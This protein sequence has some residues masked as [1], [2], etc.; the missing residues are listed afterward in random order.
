[1]ILVDSS[2]WI[3]YFRGATN[4]QTEVLDALLGQQPLAIGDLILTEVL[5]GFDDE[6][7]FN[8]ARKM[9]TALTIVELGGEEIAIQAARNFR[10]LRRFGVTVRKTIDTVI[11]TRCIESGYD[12]LHN[13][14]D[15]D[16]FARHLGLVV[17]AS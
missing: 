4:V 3:D 16:P 15:F 11:A 14:R 5:Q 12:L 9:L 8:A 1:M 7:D 10:A 13:D 2:V 6:R 17:V